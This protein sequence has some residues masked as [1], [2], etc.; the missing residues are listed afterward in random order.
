METYAVLLE[1]ADEHVREQGAGFVRVADVFEGFRCVFRYTGIMSENVRIEEER[2]RWVR[3]GDETRGG[4]Y[5][6]R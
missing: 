1:L 3:V 6:S 2:G 4:T 5:R